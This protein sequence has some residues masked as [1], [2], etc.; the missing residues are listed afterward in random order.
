MEGIRTVQGA[1]YARS[2]QVRLDLLKVLYSVLD[3]NGENKQR[4]VVGA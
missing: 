4:E 2:D 1:K 3:V